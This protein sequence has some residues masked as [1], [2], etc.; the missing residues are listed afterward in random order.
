MPIDVI[1]PFSTGVFAF[2]LRNRI[3]P[4]GVISC[5]IVPIGDARS[6]DNMQTRQ[7]PQSVGLVI[8]TNVRVLHR[9][10]HIRMTSEFH[11]LR[12]RLTI[13]REPRNVRVTTGG[14]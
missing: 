3:V 14:M 6:A 10:L 9:H 13:L 8:K 11:R 1:T 7:R 2:G 4:L 12:Q 5:R